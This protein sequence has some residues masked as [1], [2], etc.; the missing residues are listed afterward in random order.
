[1]HGINIKE[2]SVMLAHPKN[3]FPVYFTE[4]KLPSLGLLLI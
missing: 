1:M 2:A 3:A 4:T